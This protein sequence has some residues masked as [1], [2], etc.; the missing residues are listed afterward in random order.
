MFAVAA[1][2]IEAES[3]AGRGWNVGF[4]QAHVVI[5]HS[6]ALLVFEGVESLLLLHTASRPPPASDPFVPSLGRPSYR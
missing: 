2:C 3:G 4:E 5:A 6:A 1:M